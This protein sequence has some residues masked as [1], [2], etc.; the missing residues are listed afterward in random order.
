MKELN[1]A[2]LEAK[3]EQ[4]CLMEPWEQVS[5]KSNWNSSLAQLFFYQFSM[6]LL[7]VAK[8][9][10]LVSLLS[11]SFC[12]IQ[13]QIFRK[14]VII[15]VFLSNSISN[16][17]LNSLWKICRYIRQYFDAKGAIQCK[18]DKQD[19]KLFSLLALDAFYNY[20]SNC[21]KFIQFFF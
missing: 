9:G 5:L 3:M 11:K 13:F 4:N 21:F 7:R 18:I 20:F 2:I 19:W 17:D 12:Q 14:F 6:D 10:D 16:I 15:K 1:L 8:L